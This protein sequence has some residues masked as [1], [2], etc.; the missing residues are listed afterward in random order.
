MPKILKV[1]HST[2][3]NI[4]FY[5]V[6]LFTIAGMLFYK[7]I[8][9]VPD[10]SFNLLLYTVI[11]ILEKKKWIQFKNSIRI[12]LIA[13]IFTHNLIGELI[14]LYDNPVS[15]LYF[16]KV[17][18]L[19]GTFS[20]SLFAFSLVNCIERFPLITRFQYFIFVLILGMSI[21]AIFELIEFLL[22]VILKVKN[23]RDL[24]DTNLDMLFD[25]AGSVFAGLVAG[26]KK[27]ALLKN[28]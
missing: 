15:F 28:S 2:L 17:F 18:H 11:L 7:K 3:C 13:T 24:V 27:T 20:I 8:I 9:Y 21:G 16:D 26:R 6:Q 22:D 1:S 10:A 5:I 14:G 12:L 19:F 23:Q 4:I 25:L